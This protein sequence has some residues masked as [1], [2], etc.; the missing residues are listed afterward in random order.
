MFNKKWTLHR[1][2]KWAG[3]TAAFWLL[4]LG[5]T[6]FLLD[7]RDTWRWLWQDGVSES[8]VSNVV[9]DKSKTGQIKYYQ[10]N[11]QN[12]QHH[13]AGGLTGLW[14]SENA[15][16]EWNKF[17]FEGSEKDPMI[18]M[19]IFS[20]NNQLWIATDDGVWYSEKGI[21][22]A[23]QIT[24]KEKPISALSI[25]EKT[26][27]LTGVIDRTTIFKYLINTYHVYE[28]DIKPVNKDSLPK[29]I[30]LSRFTRDIHYGRGVFEIP[31][32]LLWNDVSAIA[33]I[34]LPFSGFL[35]YWLPKKWRR[36]KSENIKVNHRVKKQSMRW[37]F[38]FHGPTFGLV[39]AIPII[40]LSLTGILLDHGKELRGWMKS[41]QITRVWQTPVYD[42]TSWK[43]EIYGIINY[44]NNP[45]KFSVGTRL[46][47]FTTEDNG[48]HW[49]REKT[50]NNDAMFIWTLRRHKE[51]IF[52]GGM[53]GP[54]MVKVNNQPW[55]PVKSV[56]HMPSDITI[57]K[58]SS[59]IWKS[60]HGLKSGNLEAGFSHKH[61]DLPTINYIPWFYILDGLHSGMLIHSQWK[62]IN[63]FIAILAIFLV[64]TG[65]IRWWRKKWI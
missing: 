35:F 5:F 51:N 58:D 19:V 24:L 1:L 44:P 45:D 32:S 62:W 42:L 23:K 39:A 28:L 56:G 11:P 21:K 12:S 31:L 50:L 26:N 61:V 16:Q 4:I 30:S 29:S 38:R 10:I 47:L 33:M 53:G 17:Q 43:G 13:I 22:N 54:N 3:L 52:I 59:W 6:G 63:D 40:Y 37:L 9:V 7:H 64:I 65:L 57:D 49:L 48:Q 60:R 34:I 15:G 18:S 46:G 27:T 2:H 8:W 14:W 55:L 36:N 20:S 41:I 25:N